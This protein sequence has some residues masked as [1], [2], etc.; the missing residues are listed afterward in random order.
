VEKTSPYTEKGPHG[1]GEKRKPVVEEGK[2]SALEGSH[3]FSRGCSLGRGTGR[4][5]FAIR[6]SEGEKVFYL[7]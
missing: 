5:S 7:S 1:E 4:T 3:F 6:I 2:A